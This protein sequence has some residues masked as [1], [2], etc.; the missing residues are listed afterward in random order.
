MRDV[1]MGAS[2]L[3]GLPRQAPL[4]CLACRPTTSMQRFTPSTPS[5]SSTCALVRRGAPSGH[6]RPGAPGSKALNEEGLVRN[7][8]VCVGGGRGRARVRV[9]ILSS[10]LAGGLVRLPERLLRTQRRTLPPHGAWAVVI[11]GWVSGQAEC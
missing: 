4:P 1:G 9:R 2:R 7:K 10:S 3:R 8:N 6:P 5:P 11:V